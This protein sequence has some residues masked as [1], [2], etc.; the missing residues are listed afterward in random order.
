MVARTNGHRKVQRRA[1]P[2]ARGRRP[3]GTYLDL[4]TQMLPA[5]P[6]SGAGS[7]VVIGG[8][9]DKQGEKVILREVCSRIRRGK[10]VVATIATAHPDEV[11]QEYR[12][13]FRSLRVAEIE[14]LHIGAGAVYVVD[15]LKESY[16]NV[17]EE[18]PGQ[19][20]SVFDLK[21]H[22]LSRDDEFNFETRRPV[23]A[24]A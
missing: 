5:L 21:L 3:R 22:I 7:L 20:M 16:T 15:G 6:G 18:K 12:G 17:S 4:Q 1:T 14:H 9:E 23:S 10:L 8:H 24:A 2:G 13:I 19:V 11:W